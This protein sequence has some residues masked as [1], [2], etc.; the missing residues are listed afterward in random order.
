[1]AYLAGGSAIDDFMTW[2]ETTP[3][4]PGTGYLTN[5]LYQWPRFRLYYEFHKRWRSGKPF[6]KGPGVKY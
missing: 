4:P 1:M 6:P 2:L 3:G 5:F